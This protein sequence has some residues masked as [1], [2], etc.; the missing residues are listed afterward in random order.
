MKNKVKMYFNLGIEGRKEIMKTK[1]YLAGFY[2]GTKG[3]TLEAIEY[4][5]EKLNHPEQHLKVV[6]VAGTNGK[7]SVCEMLST[8]LE[9][10]G[11]KVG[12]FMSPHI[13]RFSERI[14]VNHEEILEEELEKLT[15]QLKPFVEE[16]NHIHEVKVTLFEIETAMAFCY[17]VEKKCDIVVVE[18]GLGGLV[19][20]TNVVHPVVSIITSIGY[21][22]MDILG[23]TLEEIALQKA[24]IIKENSETIFLC[25]EQVVNAIIE[26]T[27]RKK[28]NVLHEIR[29]EDFGNIFYQDG[30]QVFDYKEQKQVKINLKGKKQIGNACMVLEAI[31]VLQ[32][33]G[34]GIPRETVEEGLTKVIHKARFEQIYQNPTIIFDGG[35]NEPAIC[36]LKET[37]HQYYQ[38]KEKVYVLSILKTKDYKTVIKQLME[39]TKSIFIFT[40]GTKEQDEVKCYVKKEDLLK[41]A[42]KYRRNDLYVNSLEGALAKCKNEYKNKTIFIVGSFY[43]YKEVIENLKK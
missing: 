42:L 41:E 27:C 21:D 24:G 31:N 6:H 25:Q 26:E 2:K 30:Y 4:F 35:H 34:Y 13:V 36:N 1:E 17:F 37:I 16:Y 7:G 12:L 38:N 9:Q 22:H 11:Y 43:T 40:D 8:V 3:P 32:Q 19:D 23:N 29:K 39:D 15:N 20:C 18:T 5:M 14:R 33:K 10:A 28:N